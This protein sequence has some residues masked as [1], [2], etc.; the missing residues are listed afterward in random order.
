MR[1]LRIEHVTEFDFG[2]EV[3]LLPHRL[4]LRPRADHSVRV[5]ASVLEIAPAATVRWQRDVYGNS[6]AVAAFAAPATSLR[7]ASLVDVEHYE[8]APLDFLVDDY[9]L[10]YPFEYSAADKLALQPLSAVLWPEQAST[11]EGWLA[12]LSLPRAGIETFALLDRLNRTIA[13]DFRYQ[14]REMEGVQQPAQTLASRSGSC[15]DFATLFMEACHCLGLAAR[16]VSGYNVSDASGPG[17]THAWVDVFLPGPGWKSFDPT[18]GIV[19]GQQHIAVAVARHPELVPP[20]SGSFVA[21]R[22]LSPT[23]TVSVRVHDW[24]G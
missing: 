18:A 3:S 13:N 6:L 19:A 11:V 5:T 4:L 10:T 16:F 21:P 2:S 15:R 8:V 24:K 17:S 20:V 14:A 1:R 9:A 12:S 22:Q 23:M 7:I